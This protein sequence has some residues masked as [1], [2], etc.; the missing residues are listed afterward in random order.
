M[1]TIEQLRALAAALPEVTEEPHFERTSFRV[2]KKI[3]ATYDVQLKRASFK[4]TELDQS[5][6]CSGDRTIIYPVDNKWGKQGWTLVDMTKVHKD[7]FRDLV[8][9]AY[10][11]VAPERLA[12]LVRPSMD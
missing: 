7:L 9:T 12:K 10:C 4:L 6:F 2:G 1:I 11:T 8:Q 5:V 3:F